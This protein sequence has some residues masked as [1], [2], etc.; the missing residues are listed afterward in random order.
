MSSIQTFSPAQI[1]SFRKGGK[2]L[3][4][5]LEM[6]RS[7]VAVGVTTGALD[8]L[9]E[10]FIRERGGEPAFQGYGGFPATLC[11][12]VNE[13]CVHGL[14]GARKLAEGD[15]V[16]LDCGV[17]FEG[18]V[19]DACIT[20]PVGRISPEAAHLLEV[21]QQALDRA[22]EVLRAGIRVGDLSHA[23]GEVVRRGACTVVKPLTGHGLGASVHHPPDIPNVG[24]RGTGPVLPAGT[25][26]A[27][28]PIVSIADDDVRM[29]ADGWTLVTKNGSLCAHAEH[30]LLVTEGGCA[31]I[32]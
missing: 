17:R 18:L 10:S 19:T 21:T 14:P 3:R 31:V 25:V 20:V 5:C 7:A 13:E 16:S 15:I 27:V 2:I 11:T 8:A 32:A 12:S 30:T 26:I 24:K 1:E 4:A 29:L 23:I 6:L 22:V 28:E 9:A